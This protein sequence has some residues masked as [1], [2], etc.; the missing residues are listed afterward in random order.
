M[1]DPCGGRVRTPVDER[2]DVV[3]GIAKALLVLEE[4]LIRVGWPCVLPGPLAPKG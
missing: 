2:A 3:P 4:A 1:R